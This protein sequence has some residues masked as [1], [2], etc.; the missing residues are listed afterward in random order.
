MGGKTQVRIPILESAAVAAQ[1]VLTYDG[2]PLG[3]EE[4][5]LLLDIFGNSVNLDPV[6]I[7]MTDVG[8]KGR[9]YTLGNTIRIPRGTN[10]DAGTLVHE[11]THV[12]QYQTRGTAYISDS[13]VHQMISGE[14]AYLVE[15]VP[16]QSFYDYTAEQEAVIVQ[17]YYEES[18]PGWSTNPDVIRMIEEIRRARP[19]SASAVQQDTWFGPNRPFLDDGPASNSLNRG[20]QTVPLIRIEF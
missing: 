6:Q 1:R 8:V 7:A 16:G 12:W 2:R 13:S 9:P 20:P 14:D 17:R 10:F 5:R 3:P 18:P 4:R 15:L 11:M 19:L